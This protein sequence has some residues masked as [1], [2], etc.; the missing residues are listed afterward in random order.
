MDALHGRGHLLLAAVKGEKAL[1][2]KYGMNAQPSHGE[3]NGEQAQPSYRTL[4]GKLQ[5]LLQRLNAELHMAS[6][7]L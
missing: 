6:L 3:H 4:P 5:L 2:P 1:R 7:E